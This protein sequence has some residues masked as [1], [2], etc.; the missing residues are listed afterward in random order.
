[1]C[2]CRMNFIPTIHLF[3]YHDIPPLLI[4]WGGLVTHV[5]CVVLFIQVFYLPRHFVTNRQWKHHPQSNNIPIIYSILYSFVDIHIY[6]YKLILIY[7]E[8]FVKHFLYNLYK[9]TIRQMWFGNIVFTL[10]IVWYSVMFLNHSVWHW[11][12]PIFLIPFYGICQISKP[13][14]AWQM[15]VVMRVGCWLLTCNSPGTSQ[16]CFLPREQSTGR[17]APSEPTALYG[18][19]Q[20]SQN[21]AWAQAQLQQLGNVVHLSVRLF[22]TMLLCPRQG[23]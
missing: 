11:Y 6:L 3:F 8:C 23:G 1:M 10:S 9:C 12:I 14:L 18:T 22:C 20:R 2:W 5:Q 4:H 7:Y 19:S 15:F 17:S 13:P 21:H 16:R